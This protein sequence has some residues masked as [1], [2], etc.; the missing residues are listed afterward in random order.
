MH[1]RPCEG[2]LEVDMDYPQSSLDLYGKAWGELEGYVRRGCFCCLA[3]IQ[4]A[5]FR[6]RFRKD[7]HQNSGQRLFTKYVAQ[8]TCPGFSADGG[9]G[10]PRFSF[11][12]GNFASAERNRGNVVEDSE[13]S[14]DKMEG[15]FFT[16]SKRHEVYSVQVKV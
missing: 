1:G 16:F 9:G 6:V 13:P 15:A 4:H 8:N 11:A 14:R 12:V 7:L 3:I 5:C 10:S 2:H